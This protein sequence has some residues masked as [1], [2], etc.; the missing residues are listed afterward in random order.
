MISNAESRL[1]D[2]LVYALKERPSSIGISVSLHDGKI[3][4]RYTY[5]DGAKKKNVYVSNASAAGALNSLAR[6]VHAIF[7][8]RQEGAEQL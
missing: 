3:V 1:D 4:A 2:R 5:S 7:H 8:P 6:K